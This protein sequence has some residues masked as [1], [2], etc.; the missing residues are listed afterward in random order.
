MYLYIRYVLI[1]NK[2]VVNKTIAKSLN[3]IKS[4]SNFYRVG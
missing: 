2:K 1:L 4:Q 3:S